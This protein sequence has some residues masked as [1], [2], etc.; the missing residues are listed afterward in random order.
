M[1]KDKLIHSVKKTFL[2]KCGTSAQ[3]S[4]VSLSDFNVVFL[5]LPIPQ[6][7]YSAIQN[8]SNVILL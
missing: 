3:I 7:Y 5:V 4:L 6:Q 2:T 8:S 1:L